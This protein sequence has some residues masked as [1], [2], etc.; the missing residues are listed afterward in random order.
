MYFTIPLYSFVPSRDITKSDFVKLCKLLSSDSYRVVLE[1]ITEG[2][3]EFLPTNKELPHFPA[4][5]KESFV[6]G[7]TP[8]K[9]FAIRF[10]FGIYPENRDTKWPYITDPKSWIDNDEIVMVAGGGILTT[11]A[12]GISKSKDIT[13]NHLIDVNN[14]IASF[15]TIGF[16]FCGDS[17]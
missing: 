9:Y 4:D 16:K 5:R 11:R 7:E 12:K 17:R 10:N 13:V 3:L 6:V 15:E 8:V 1:G 2:G 14:F